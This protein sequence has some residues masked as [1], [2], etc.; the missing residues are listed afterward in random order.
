MNASFR[1]LFV[2]TGNICRSPMA[3]GIMKV[4]L[5]P[6]SGCHIMV[7]SAGTRAA[8]GLPA[9]P[10]AV[11]AARELGADI[12]GHRSRSIDGSLI[13]RADLI[14]VMERQQARFIRSA[15]QVAPDALRLLG[16]FAGGEGTPEIP[17]P[18]GGSFGVY[19]HCAQM[20][21][22][23]LDGVIDIARVQASFRP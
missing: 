18:Y 9:E 3:E 11:R 2:C 16:E 22:R 20:I 12:G 13:A 10:G 4:L 23:C 15:A 21:R 19:R 5:P 8:D 7:C 14:L 6:A 17:D 1:L